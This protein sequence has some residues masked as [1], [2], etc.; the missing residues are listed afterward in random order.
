MISLSDIQ[1]VIILYKCELHNSSS[2]IS[3]SNSLKIHATI[4]NVNLYVHDNTP[5]WQNYQNSDN[6]WEITYKRDELNGGLSKAY[7]EASLYA[8]S[9]GKQYLFLLDQ[10]TTFPDYALERYLKAINRNDHINLFAPI[11]RIQTG[12][13]MSPCKYVNKWGKLVD[14]I[15]YG[16][17]H[18]D[19]YV[20]VN[21]GLC[22]KLESFFK[23]GGYNEKIKVDGADFQFL[24]RFKRQVSKDFYVLDLE[25]I[26]DFSLF[27]NDLNN[28]FSRFKIFLTDV[29]NFERDDIS[30]NYYYGRIALIRTLKLF[31]QTK[32]FTVLE[33]YIKFYLKSK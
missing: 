13:I 2:F 30:D 7:N 26:Q 14:N 3:L 31:F 33:Y 12:K 24:E 5:Y 9:N 11:I 10:D 19:S 1:F 28:I 21:S 8:K 29:S 4:S 32:S 20:P 25:I 22:I 23:A 6:L 18:L 16:I 27:E 15:Q 17:H